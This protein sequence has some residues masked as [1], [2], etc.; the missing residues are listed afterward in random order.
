M[1]IKVRNKKEKKKRK[2]TEEKK[3][4]WCANKPKDKNFCITGLKLIKHD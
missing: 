2:K 4:M 1:K 3:T